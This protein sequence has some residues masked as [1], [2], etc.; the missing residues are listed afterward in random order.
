MTDP[1][2]PPAPGNAFDLN[3]RQEKILD[4]VQRHG[5][6]TVETLA[7]RFGVTTQTIRRDI[8]RMESLGLLLR[9]HGGASLPNATA[10]RGYAEKRTLAIGAKAHIARAVADLIPDGASVFL[11]VGTTVEAVAEALRD[12][13]GLRVFTNNLRAAGI[14]AGQPG[15][16]LFVAGGFVRG[17]DGSLVGECVGRALA[18]LRP[19]FAII[20]YSGF[21]D[22]AALMDF[23]MQ[24]VA[25]KQM[26]IARARAALAV[27]DS[28]KFLRGATVRIAAAAAFHGLVSDAPPPDELAAL[29]DAAGVVFHQA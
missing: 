6:V 20:G 7:G 19:D 18:D 16:E 26:M 23:D 11:D 25:V 4:L 9:F 29:L 5:F 17:A 21:D 24:K 14:L 15:V 1:L 28:G 8:I 10:R 22:D 3:D 27:G 13:T 2:L 12:K